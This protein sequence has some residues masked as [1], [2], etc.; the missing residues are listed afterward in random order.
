MQRIIVNVHSL[1]R[2]VDSM[3]RFYFK[4]DILYM[5]SNASM[6]GELERMQKETAVPELE[7]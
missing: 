3:G 7:A 4:L 5:A 6:T 2:S 1:N